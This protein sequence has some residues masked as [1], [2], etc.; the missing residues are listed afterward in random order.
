MTLFALLKLLHVSSALLSI[1]G[2]ALRGYWA[3]TDNPLRQAKPVRV[4]PHLVDTLLLGSA[5]GMLLVWKIP[6]AALPWVVAKLLALLL[7]IGL[8]M[9]VMRFAQT[10]RTRLAAYLA[11]LATAG[12][13]IAVAL[14]HSPWGPLALIG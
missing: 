10:R 12:Y 4:L 3:V 2:F 1:S 13:I 7:Y 8:G 14:T 5:I 11:A 9:V 6:L